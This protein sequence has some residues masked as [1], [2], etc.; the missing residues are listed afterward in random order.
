MDKKIFLGWDKKYSDNYN[1]I[2]RK[3]LIKRIKY[4]LDKMLYELFLKEI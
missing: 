1:R 3:S 4:L 2:F